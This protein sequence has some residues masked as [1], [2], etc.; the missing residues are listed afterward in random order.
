M[1]RFANAMS[2][3]SAGEGFEPFHLVDVYPWDT[4]KAKVFVDVGG[5]CGTSSIAIAQHCPSIR[6]IV[7][8][9]PEVVSKGKSA[10]S[11]ELRSRIEFMPHD[12]FKEQPVKDADVYFFRWIF[13]DWSDKYCVKILRNT[14]PA[15][16][17]GAR[18]I[19]S[20]FV[21]PPPG[22][23][24]AYQE[25]LA[26]WDLHESYSRAC[27]LTDRDSEHSTLRC[28]SCLIRKSVKRTI[29]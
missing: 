15:L 11:P 17:A 19:I 29:G 22:V 14:I 21:V 5:S 9:L 10:L 25:W 3:I 1:D 4:A 23:A 13:H 24:S 16:K 6:C 2:M 18:I 7:Q 8:D 12:F 28:W 20:E 27:K 26:R